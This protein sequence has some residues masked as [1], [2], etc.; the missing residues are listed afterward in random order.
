[1]K[2][3]KWSAVGINLLN[4]LII[5]SHNNAVIETPIDSYGVDIAQYE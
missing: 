1:M 3:L 2:F 4:C 5:L